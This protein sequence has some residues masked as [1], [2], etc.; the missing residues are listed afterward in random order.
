M[1]QSRRGTMS[2]RLVDTA[3]R[4]LS[5]IATKR[6]HTRGSGLSVSPGASLVTSRY[7]STHRVVLRSYIYRGR[8]A[9]NQ[10][11]VG[12]PH[13]NLT[14]SAAMAAGSRHELLIRHLPRTSACKPD[15]QETP[16]FCTL[17]CYCTCHRRDPRA[18]KI[19]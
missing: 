10:R 19:D 14:I 9:T 15:M 3:T 6:Q 5:N 7:L 1:S 17:C 18:Y 12:G 2:C 8:Q 16:D 11:P 4:R 13:I